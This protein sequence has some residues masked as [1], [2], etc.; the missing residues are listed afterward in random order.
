[1]KLRNPGYVNH[2]HE[3][4][5]LNHGHDVGH[6]EP[7]STFEISLTYTHYRIMDSRA[8]QM[9]LPLLTGHISN[10]YLNISMGF[11]SSATGAPVSV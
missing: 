7:L 10:R 9:S 1:M 3:V 6:L 8:M 4:G 5:Y 2:G 11:L